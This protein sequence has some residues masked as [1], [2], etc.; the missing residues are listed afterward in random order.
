MRLA[1]LIC[2]ALLAGAALLT[3]CALG[4][5]D[6]D[7]TP[8]VRELDEG[9]QLGSIDRLPGGTAVASN[10]RTLLTVSCDGDV[11]NIRTN[12]ESITADMPC[13]RLFPQTVIDKFI[14]KPVAI[15]FGGGRLKVESDIEGTLDFPAEDPRVSDLNATP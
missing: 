10:V 13:D 4:L 8:G 1:A 9:D 6:D 5:D 7:G 15:S 2:C 11:L 14:A 3:G 12:L